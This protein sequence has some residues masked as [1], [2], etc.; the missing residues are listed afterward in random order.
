[1]FSTKL[2]LYFPVRYRDRYRY[3]YRI[4]FREPISSGFRIGIGHSIGI[5]R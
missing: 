1:M 5:E 4:V 2:F 3:R